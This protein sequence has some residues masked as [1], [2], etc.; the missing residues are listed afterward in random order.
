[1]NGIQRETAP[2]S[3]ILRASSSVH[4]YGSITSNTPHSSTR[5]KVISVT[6]QDRT[7]SKAPSSLATHTDD[8]HDLQPTG[9]QGTSTLITLISQ[10]HIRAIL[11]VNFV[12]NVVRDGFDEVFALYSYTRVDLGGMGLTPSQIGWI[13]SI[14]GTVGTSS[15]LALPYLQYRFN[16]RHLYTFFACFTPVTF[17]LMP[18]GHLVASQTNG[19]AD[20]RLWVALGIILIPTKIS[21]NLYPLTMII[22]KSSVDNPSHLGSMFGFQQTTASI[23]R[24]IAPYFASSLFALSVGRNLLGGNLVWVIMVL[25]GLCGVWMSTRVRNVQ[26]PQRLFATGRND[27]SMDN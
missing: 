27:G 26:A 12:F 18:I 20:S 10:P 16:N 17:A 19:T 24:G 15:L 8:N 1:M 9:Q 25:L 21:V 11:A 3:S 7:T 4:H 6:N 22:V 23:A 5:A 14:S 2:T 13:L